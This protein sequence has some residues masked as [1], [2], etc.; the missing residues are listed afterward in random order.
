MPSLCCLFASSET[1]RLRMC[2]AYALLHMT[3]T[4]GHFPGVVYY[5]YVYYSYTRSQVAQAMTKLRWC[6][7]GP[8]AAQSYL[9]LPTA[10]YQPDSR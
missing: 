5:T 6:Q 4:V 2:R 10:V 7:G 3:S 9:L 1:W 8:R